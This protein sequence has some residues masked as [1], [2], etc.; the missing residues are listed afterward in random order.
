MHAGG[1]GAGQGRDFPRVQQ[2]QRCPRA[3][4]EGPP[5]FIGTI[6][7]LP[8][9]IR[10]QFILEKLADPVNRAHFSQ[11]ASRLTVTG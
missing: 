11:S 7:H 9:P 8:A 2:S 1:N 10:T 3:P 6:M 5:A 4:P